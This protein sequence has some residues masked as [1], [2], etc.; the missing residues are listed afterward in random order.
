MDDQLKVYAIGV[1]TSEGGLIPIYN[2]TGQVTDYK[3]DKKTVTLSCL[4]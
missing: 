3:K 1:G 2:E 4:S